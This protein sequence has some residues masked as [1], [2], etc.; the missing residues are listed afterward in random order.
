MGYRIPK[1]KKMN[2]ADSIIESFERYK[3]YKEAQRAMNDEMT[4]IDNL[5]KTVDN[6]QKELEHVDALNADLRRENAAL[7]RVIQDELD[8]KIARYKAVVED[9]EKNGTSW[10]PD[11]EDIL[12]GRYT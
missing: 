4:M 12:N 6:L 1:D 8:R 2:K 7:R 10:T 5:N 9:F 3:E 11:I